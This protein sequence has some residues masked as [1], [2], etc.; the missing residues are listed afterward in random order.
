[1]LSDENEPLH[2][3]ITHS[4]QP[5]ASQM[6]Y[7]VQAAHLFI[8]FVGFGFPA[9][10]SLLQPHPYELFQRFS[11]C[12]LLRGKQFVVDL[13]PRVSVDILPLPISHDGCTI[14][15]IFPPRY[16]HSDLPFGP[17]YQGQNIRSVPPQNS[18]Y[19]VP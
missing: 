6:G 8:A 10:A 18:A 1:M 11:V 5:D 19:L 14:S 13:L 9:G 15:P 2:I 3:L 4:L 16:P 7:D 17:A 12:A